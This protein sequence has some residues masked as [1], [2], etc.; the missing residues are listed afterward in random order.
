MNQD[1]IWDHF[2]NEGGDSF[3]VARP[4]VDFVARQ[5]VRGERT[6]NI[7]VGIG[8][9]ERLAQAKGVDIWAL[10]PGERAIARLRED[11]GLADQAKV[12]YSQDM[13]F[14]DGLFDT[15]IMS[16]VLE[17]LDDEVLTATLGEVHRVLR[18]GGRFIGTV[19][20]RENLANAAVVCPDCGNHFHRWG[21]QRSFTVEQMAEQLK[22]R[23]IID[24][25][26]ER[27]LVDWDSVGFM[28][29]LAGLVKRFL[30]WR[31]IGAYGACRNIVFTV[32]KR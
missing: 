28:G 5:L 29:K 31:G 30:S 8:A 25:V 17:H 21:H 1:L 7:G 15:V 23:F 32:N 4:R 3:L 22:T 14:A 10:D 26:Q 6:L 18:P 19:P 13:P 9:L 20:A 27:F 2:Q 12:G 16:E 11:L 24:K